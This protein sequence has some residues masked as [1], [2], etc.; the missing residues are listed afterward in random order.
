[1]KKLIPELDV[2]CKGILEQV[3]VENARMRLEQAT[4]FK[5]MAEARDDRIAQLLQSQAESQEANELHN[6]ALVAKA[7]DVEVAKV[8][9][10]W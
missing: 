4:H 9:L 5:K 2:R 8:S 10:Q 3:Q 1:M 7:L 6:R